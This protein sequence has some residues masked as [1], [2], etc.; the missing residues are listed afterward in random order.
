MAVMIPMHMAKDL[1]EQHAKDLRRMGAA[2]QPFGKSAQMVPRQW[3]NRRRVLRD[4]VGLQRR[5]PMWWGRRRL[6][7]AEGRPCPG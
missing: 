7:A 5:I 3:R 1:A 6:A 2:G 4:H